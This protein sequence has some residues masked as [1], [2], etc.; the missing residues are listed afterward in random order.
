MAIIFSS[1]C[2]IIFA[3][4]ISFRGE[5]LVEMCRGLSRWVF[6]VCKHPIESCSALGDKI[7][8]CNYSIQS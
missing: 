5:S 8:T 7:S 1:K 3:K 6:W 2:K 4:W